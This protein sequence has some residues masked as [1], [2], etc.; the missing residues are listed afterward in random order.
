MQS[1]GAGL[2]G[3]AV[4]LFSF[5]PFVERALL[6]RSCLPFCS[7]IVRN[8]GWCTGGGSYNFTAMRTL[9]LI[10]EFHGGTEVFG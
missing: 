9:E 3:G 4:R 7:E 8:Q 2:P 10:F 1:S 6:L 5:P